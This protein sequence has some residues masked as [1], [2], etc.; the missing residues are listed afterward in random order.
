MPGRFRVVEVHTWFHTMR[1]MD[2][3]E[4]RGQKDTIFLILTRKFTKIYF[5]IVE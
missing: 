3:M 4:G 1:R 2:M 5:N